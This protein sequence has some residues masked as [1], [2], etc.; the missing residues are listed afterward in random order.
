MKRPRISLI[1]NTNDRKVELC[2]LLYS[3]CRQSLEEFEVVVV[4]G[5]AEDGTA[6]MLE[7]EFWGRVKVE[8]CPVFNLSV[9]RNLGLERAAGEIVAFIDDDAL[10]STR[11]LEQ[12]LAAY[13]DERVAGA[14]GRTY[15]VRDD[16][17]RLQF[18]RGQFS[19]VAEQKDVLWPGESLPPSPT[20]AR[21][22]FPRFHGTN[23]SYRRSA[24][25]AIG[26]FDERFEYLYDDGDLGVRLGLAGFRLR[27][28][29]DGVVYHLGSSTGNRGRHPY[30]LNWYSWSRSQIYFALQNGRPAVGL[31]RSLVAA[32]RN[33]AHLK[34][35]VRELRAAGE[36]P[37]DLYRKATKMLRRA[38]RDGLREG[39]FAERR[40]PGRILDRSGAFCPFQREVWRS[41]PA[42]SPGNP[43]ATTRIRPLPSPPLRLALLSIDYPPAST[44]GVA[45]ST[46]TL[47][48]G[49]AELGHEVH[50][51]TRGESHRTHSRHGVWI[52]DVGVRPVD[53]YAEMA[54]RGYP[55]LAAWLEHS[56]EAWA[57]TRGLIANHGIQLV[58]SPLW[59]LDGYVAAI[60]DEIP[61]AVRVVT[62][63]RQIASVHGELQR[64]NVLL[65]DL[66]EDFLKRASLL[67]SNSAATE[68]TLR[69]IYGIDVDERRHGLVSYGH[70]PRDEAEV[71]PAS[72]SG[73][74]TVLFVG[75]LEGRKGITELFDAIPLALRSLPGL[76]FVLAGS[77]NSRHDG[78]FDREGS[79]IRPGSSAGTPR[80][81]HAS[82][83]ADT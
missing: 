71:K 59:N 40:I 15:L 50:V 51:V 21:F 24:L 79:T 42:I 56:H 13:E 48:R 46:E 22:W 31:R 74:P 20:P 73:Q 63:M 64:E 2:A 82:S 83:S 52:H 35:M 3:L 11:W 53:R 80:R 32:L 57:T 41:A 67:V 58:D 62:A 43:P 5:P 6:E 9:S 69:R 77:D 30:D 27:Q 78:F 14:G 61:V 7:E 17:N 4:V 81:R 33:A 8:R 72:G 54:A 75:R 34:S 18:F 55:N 19:V 47:A 37:P 36:L 76:R 23:M 38:L 70:I 68:E 26:G 44:H 65:G 39:L 60:A 28:L 49:L 45:R 1:V 10:P 29:D 25:Q 66:E 12:L 16:E